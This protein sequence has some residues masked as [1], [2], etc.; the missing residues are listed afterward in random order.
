MGGKAVDLL[1]AVAPAGCTPPPEVGGPC[2]R[3]AVGLAPACG[4]GVCIGAPGTG[5]RCAC[6]P[7]GGNCV[8]FDGRG[9]AMALP[10]LT[11]GAWAATLGA[12]VRRIATTIATT[13]ITLPTIHRQPP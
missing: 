3:A 10:A 6:W 12:L 4:T 1:G 2:G 9:G 13:A 7:A 5:G 8:G 11:T